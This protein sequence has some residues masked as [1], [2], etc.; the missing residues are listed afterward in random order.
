MN[1]GR[2]LNTISDCNEVGKNVQKQNAYRTHSGNIKF[3]TTLA[4]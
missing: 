1:T 3:I 4:I 2:K